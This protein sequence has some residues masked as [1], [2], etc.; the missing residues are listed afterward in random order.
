MKRIYLFS[1]ALFAMM[2]A[3]KTVS[4]EVWTGTCGYFANYTFDTETGLLTISG[5]GSMY[6]YNFSTNK[7]PW[8]AD[9]WKDPDSYA[10]LIKNI[11][12]EEGI[13]EIG[14]FEL[15]Y[16]IQS[17]KFPSSLKK[18]RDGAFDYTYFSSA[19]FKDGL[20]EIGASAFNKTHLSMISIPATVKEIGE[21][22]FSYHGFSD[23]YVYWKTASEIP[24]FSSI[25]DYDNP[26]YNGQE[27]SNIK[28]HV[29]K[30]TAAFYKIKHTWKEFNIVEDADGSELCDIHYT[31]RP[32]DVEFMSG[33]GSVQFNQNPDCEGITIIEAVPA[34]GYSFYKWSDGN[35][36][37]PRTINLSEQPEFTADEGTGTFF[38]HFI[39]PSDIVELDFTVDPAGGAELTITDNNGDVHA[40]GKFVPSTG[41]NAA[42]VEIS[43]AEGYEFV[44]WEYDETYLSSISENENHGLHIELT[45]TPMT[46]PDMGDEMIDV[47]EFPTSYILHLTNPTGVEEVM[48]INI[49]SAKKVLRD[50]QVLI[51]RND[52]TYNALGAEVK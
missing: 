21:S 31:F 27:L 11:V 41:E 16:S 50:G 20:E 52:K 3:S 35:A 22:A 14:N 23:V 47:P 7:A 40:D 45:F 43:L 12:I 33:K 19:K 9:K 17:V 38:A 42:N 4:A 28:L 18:V 6:E 10:T 29:P 5:E 15:L 30:G 49:N 1:I 36:D 8:T 39:Q 26:F 44:G 2:F 25:D 34:E 48:E 51:L 24:D 46:M 32:I 13:T 37:N